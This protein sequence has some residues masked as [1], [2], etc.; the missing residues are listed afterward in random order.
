MAA[1]PDTWL[2]LRPVFP[3]LIFERKLTSAD[4]AKA[5]KGFPHNCWSLRDPGHLL[6]TA[7]ERKDSR[8][9]VWNPTEP[10]V[11]GGLGGGSVRSEEQ[12]VMAQLLSQNF[13]F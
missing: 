11:V 2:G 13:W 3:I 1:S 12:L 7:T 4:L 9:P 8:L 6:P 5:V 10:V